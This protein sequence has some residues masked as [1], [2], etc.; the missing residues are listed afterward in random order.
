[1]FSINEI[2]TAT[3]ATAT[4][5]VMSVI[6]NSKSFNGKISP[7]PILVIASIAQ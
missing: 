3:M 1:M 2:L 5:T 6:I 7:Y 4:M